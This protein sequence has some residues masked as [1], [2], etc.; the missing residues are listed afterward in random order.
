VEVQRLSDKLWRW[1]TR[2]P[3]W[4]PDEGGPEGW[5]PEVGC[6]FYAAPEGIVLIDP[7][8]PVGGERDRFLRALDLD[9]ERDGRPPAV[10]LT[11]YWHERSAE[12][13]AARYE[14]TKIWAPAAALARMSI[15]V[16]NP[17][18]PG[19]AL[20]GGVLAFDSRRRGEVVF[21][22]PAPRALVTGDVLLGTPDGGLRVCPGSWLPKDVEPLDFRRS[23]HGL[24]ELP[25]ELVVPS[26]GAPVLEDARGALERALSA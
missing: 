19:D 6:I 13:L 22:L 8:I 11:I 18:E 12:E 1:I 20:P 16:M 4:T 14:G 26:H 21:W 24:L 17:F 25:V 9:V 23:L 5:E 10:L 7:L 2:H 15:A 3:E